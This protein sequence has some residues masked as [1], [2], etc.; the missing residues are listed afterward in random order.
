MRMS[1]G[2]ATDHGQATGATSGFSQAEVD[3]FHQDDGRSATAVVCLM[4]GIFTLGLIL[5]L[6]VCYYILN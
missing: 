6:G 3:A 4:S 2:T 5:Y 1:H